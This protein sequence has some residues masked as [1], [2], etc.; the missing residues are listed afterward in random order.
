MNKHSSAFSAKKYYKNRPLSFDKDDYNAKNKALYE[1]YKDLRDENSRDLVKYPFLIFM[2]GGGITSISEG[3]AKKVVQSLYEQLG[4]FN[5]EIAELKNLPAN[6]SKEKTLNN[7]L[8]KQ[9]KAAEVEQF[10][11]HLETLGAFVS[12]EEFANRFK[13]KE[14]FIK[15]MFAGTSTTLYLNDKNIVEEAGEVLAPRFA[16]GLNELLGDTT[17]ARGAVMQAGEILH[18]VF[19]AH[20][21]KA[22]RA[23]LKNGRTSLSKSEINQLIEDKLLEVFP[24]YKGPL[25]T[26]EER[27]LI[28]LTKRALL[29]DI[30]NETE[31]KFE[32]KNKEG[33][34]G[35]TKSAPRQSVF[36][37]PGVT[38]LIRL[39]INMDSAVLTKTLAE[40]P[41]VLMLHDAIMANPEILLEAQETYGKW[42]LK[43][44]AETS[45]LEVIHDQ[46]IEVMKIT[47]AADEAN[48]NG[49]LR[50][51][52]ENWIT[53]SSNANTF[54]DG[55]DRNP[56]LSLD[57]LMG[58]VTANKDEVLD[59]RA[60]QAKKLKDAGLVPVSR[61]LYMPLP[62]TKST[63]TPNLISQIK[64]D[65]QET[66]DGIDP[67]NKPD[68]TTP[69][70]PDVIDGPESTDPDM[71][72]FGSLDNF[73]RDNPGKDPLV[74]DLDSSNATELFSKM[75]SFSDN[76]YS[77]PETKNAH[78]SA[79]ENVLNL[80]KRG[81]DATTQTRLTIED[82]DGI[83][84]GRYDSI[85]DDLRVSLSRQAPLS[86]NGQSPQEV[87]IHELV[88]AMTFAAIRD[89]PLIAKRIEAIYNR[90]KKE[91]DA[92]GKHK[93]FLEG[94]KNPSAQDITTARRQ[95]NYLF[96]NSAKEANKLH[97][98][99]AYAVTNRSLSNYRWLRLPKL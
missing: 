63:E 3:V 97:E 44:N 72:S 92:N 89:N 40:H 30:S 68:D 16:G 88:H 33:K 77:S 12:G 65:I 27:A 6:S 39:I 82:I 20:Y 29:G 57:A 4:I 42:H 26:K 79:L 71:T 28:D 19:M 66:V 75:S 17:K 95:Y 55:S 61:Q 32:Y 83:T 48:G 49:E 70:Q 60:A 58:T 34:V 7:T 35:V 11:K 9:A 24:Q 38:A 43:L 23:A 94:I 5:A 36:V 59:A 91:L 90:T 86:V 54:A 93:V 18:A 51:E 41:N 76:Y 85:R 45:V 31:T 96:D 10:A 46:M 13:S 8:A 14:D 80:L 22:S 47:D 98:F 15:H 52:I 78:S 74:T 37:A 67:K 25:I 56:Y 87:Y 53:Y 1:V 64:D 73:P 50:R 84:Q 69:T 21:Q 81:M 2:Y 62:E 99:L